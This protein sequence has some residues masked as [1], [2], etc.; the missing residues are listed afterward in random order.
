[1]HAS[2]IIWQLRGDLEEGCGIGAAQ[3]NRP[4]CENHCC[5]FLAEEEGAGAPVTHA[6]NRQKV[7]RSAK[8]LARTMDG[9]KVGDI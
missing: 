6:F 5:A 9:I 3:E 1:M 4:L 2:L 8:N 7:P